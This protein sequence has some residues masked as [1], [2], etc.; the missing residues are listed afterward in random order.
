MKSSGN[1]IKDTHTNTYFFLISFV[2]RY[3]NYSVN[4][5][6][7]STIHCK[8]TQNS[9]YLTENLMYH[10]CLRFYL[11]C[12]PIWYGI[13][14]LTVDGVFFCIFFVCSVKNWTSFYMDVFLCLYVFMLFVHAFMHYNCE[15]QKKIKLIG[16]WN[17]NEGHKKHT[18]DNSSELRERNQ[19]KISNQYTKNE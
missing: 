15:N 18:Y 2:G 4:I 11:C 17:V 16:K 13:F 7:V 14:F 6:C 19:I 1:N 9:N 12:C 8:Y 3:W 5:L 10:A